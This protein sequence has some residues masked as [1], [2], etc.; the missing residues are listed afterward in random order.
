MYTV[1]QITLVQGDRPVAPTPLG[2]QAGMPMA[3][4]GII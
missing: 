2:V 1:L 4:R 3:K